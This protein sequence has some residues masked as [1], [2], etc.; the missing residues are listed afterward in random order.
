MS[1]LKPVTIGSPVVLSAGGVLL[2]W[3]IAS[4]KRLAITIK[5]LQILSKQTGTQNCLIIKNLHL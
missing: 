3:Q 1:Q 4:P 2:H 5:N